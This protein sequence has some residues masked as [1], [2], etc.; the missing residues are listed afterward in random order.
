MYL[1]NTIKAI[2]EDL[3]VNAVF[4]LSPEEI[5]LVGG[6]IRDSIINQK[7]LDRDFILKGN[8]NEI[9][10]K[11]SS[12]FDGTIVKL[13]ETLRVALKNGITLD[14]TEYSD[15]IEEDLSRRDFT[16]NAIAL[17]ASG[18]LIDP[19]NGVDD[20]KKGIIRMIKA[21]NLL[22]DP[23]RILRAYRFVSELDG[24]IEEQ[25]RQF[26]INYKDK[27]RYEATERITLEFLKLLEGRSPEKALKMT[28]EDNLLNIIFFF[29][30]KELDKLVKR[31]S[32]LSEN[33]EE[34]PNLISPL[35][36]ISLK[37]L[38]LLEIL[39]EESEGRSLLRLPKRI[40]KRI[41][42]FLRGQ[43][44]GCLENVS[45]EASFDC[46]ELYGEA[47]FDA[48][49]INGKIELWQQAERY[50]KISESPLLRG[51]NLL[52]LGIDEGP[53]MGNLLRLLRKAAYEGRIS[54]R[55]EAIRFIQNI[56]R[57]S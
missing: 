41:K 38:L 19:Y 24:F 37:G 31:I 45:K 1:S 43:K 42:N 50:I 10:Q 7:S 14:F 23:V 36:G 30:N 48:I 40:I 54:T 56:K 34:A 28:C 12:L 55:D 6:F 18:K 8:I 11:I 20:L 46:L 52:S 32:K 33:L 47:V 29:K 53:E 21:K 3:Y 15:S 39:M 2:L 49:I 22:N 25:T 17:S 9:T 35:K 27:I 57:H 44:S 4:E 26:I 13:K 51:E 16:F 5:Y